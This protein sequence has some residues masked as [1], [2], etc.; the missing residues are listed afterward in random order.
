[1]LD[2][3]GS[4]DGTTP[5]IPDKRLERIHTQYRDEEGPVLALDTFT[6]GARDGTWD[7]WAK[8]KPKPETD[9]R[10]GRQFLQE[11]ECVT[12]SGIAAMRKFFEEHVKSEEVGA[13]KDDW[14]W[15]TWKNEADDAG[16]LMMALPGA[17]TFFFDD[18]IESNTPHIVDCRE[19]DGRL[20]DSERI[21]H[22]CIR[23]NPV[24]ALL[25]E[26]HFVEEVGGKLGLHDLAMDIEEPFS[27]GV[28]PGVQLVDP[29][30]AAEYQQEQEG[31]LGAFFS[32]LACC[33][34]SNGSKPSS[35]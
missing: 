15:W 20:M 2:G 19:A 4:L 27:R 17:E 32:N 14:A 29:S 3:V 16:K 26:D 1:M 13:F 7:A 33:S 12:V 28:S 5:G 10:N 23:I 22:C 30:I 34:C 18:N 25:N 24:E 21:S 35:G 8:S 6:N 31:W 9:T 11:Q